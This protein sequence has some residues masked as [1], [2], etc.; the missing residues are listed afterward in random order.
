MRQDQDPSCWEVEGQLRAVRAGLGAEGG[1][2]AARGCSDG[3]KKTGRG[4]GAHETWLSLPPRMS[5]S[6]LRRGDTN[7]PWR[8]M[9]FCSSLMAVPSCEFTCCMFICTD[10]GGGEGWGGAGR[11]RIGVR[12][13]ARWAR[14]ATRHR[15][16]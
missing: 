16:A 8:A 13:L 5:D 2:A 15:R 7:R 6:H 12:Q 10:C 3:E 4:S 9:L 11:G 14:V 1:V